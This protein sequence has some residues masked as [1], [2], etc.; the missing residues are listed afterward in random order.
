MSS[1][2]G[3][4][5]WRR[6][7]GA[8]A[9]VVLV[10]VGAVGLDLPTVGAAGAA[11]D[12]TAAVS[13]RRAEGENGNLPTSWLQEVAGVLLE[14]D[15]AGAMADML[16]AARRD[17]TVVALTDG[18]RTFGQQV[19]LKATK[20]HLAAR[21]GTS[22]HGWGLAVDFDMRVTD[23]AWLR[24]HAASYGWIHP[25]WAQPGGSKPEPWHWE[26]VGRPGPA[27]EQREA[28]GVALRPNRVAGEL[29][30]TVRLEPVE[31]PAGA[32]FEVRAGFDRFEEAAGHYP[33]TTDPGAEGNFA[34]AGY[35]R[36]AGTP[37]HGLDQLEAGDTI[38]VRTPSGDELRYRVQDRA[39]LPDSEGWAVGP[40]PLENG[41]STLM[42]LTTSV[43]EGQLL[44]VWSEQ[45]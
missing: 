42:T 33:G 41:A 32:W 3:D 40:D 1:R 9:V 10:L 17:G 25:P 8:A 34:I 36:A 19:T 43:G 2:Q 23:F 30:A 15:A 14:P 11:A 16:E 21:P 20:G 5:A 7:H 13:E 27:G 26:F 31:G 29:V 22:M 44:V 38:R 37:L 6:W 45:V 28:A 35:H 24:M 18:Y 4:R 39:V 12:D